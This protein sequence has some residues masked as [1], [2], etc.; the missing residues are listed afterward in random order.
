MQYWVIDRYAA[1]KHKIQN[2]LDKITAEM[3][4]PMENVSLSESVSVK[5]QNYSLK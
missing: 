2:E 3:R 4:N 5:D 1:V